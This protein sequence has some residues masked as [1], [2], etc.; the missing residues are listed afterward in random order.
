MENVLILGD[1]YSTFQGFVPEGYD[2]YYSERQRPET[3]VTKVSQTWWHQVMEKAG[4]NLVHNN[5]WSGST[6]CYTGYNN[7][8]CSHSSSFIY[9]LRQ[10][11]AEGF[12]EKNEIH[13]VFLFGGTNDS[14]SD[15]PLGEEKFADWQEQELYCVLPAIGCICKL[16][17]DTLPK[18]DIYCLLN[19]EIKGKIIAC[20]E[21]A[22]ETFGLIPVHFDHIDK[23]CGHPTIRGM[24]DIR[25]GVLEAL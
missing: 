6:I 23:R 7:R 14:W 12:F 18:A 19:T 22:C 20:M 17:K 3:D 15:A 5:S 8:D 16:L 21:K 13:K 1:S 9:R 10:L 24:Q 11:V 2:I 25:D 4:L